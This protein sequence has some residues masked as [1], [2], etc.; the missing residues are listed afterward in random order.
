MFKC[1]YLDVYRGDPTRIK[2]NVGLAAGYLFSGECSFKFM[3]TKL[4]TMVAS[5]LG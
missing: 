1:K 3:L 2:L 5:G 4:G